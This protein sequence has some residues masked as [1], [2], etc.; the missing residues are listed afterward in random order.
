M[1][2]S[3]YPFRIAHP[4]RLQKRPRFD[5]D[6]RSA[7][8]IRMASPTATT[9]RHHRQRPRDEGLSTQR[10][11]AAPERFRVRL[12]GARQ[13]MGQMPGRERL[14]KASGR[15][16]S[17]RSVWWFSQLDRSH[18]L[19]RPHRPHRLHRPSPVPSLLR[20][21]PPAPLPVKRSAGEARDSV[22][23]HHPPARRGPGTSCGWRHGPR[24]CCEGLK[25]LNGQGGTK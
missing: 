21:V 11:R 25:D 23:C 18:H 15:P 5:F 14:A 1:R 6:R 10:K 4:A 9:R 12:F 20:V 17:M 8:A 22:R 2:S 19:H 3:R 7:T 24:R 16:E 13:G